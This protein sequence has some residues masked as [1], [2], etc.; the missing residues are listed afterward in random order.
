MSN[1]S[2]GQNITEGPISITSVPGKS[3]TTVRTW[4]GDETSIRAQA[5]LMFADGWTT[6]MEGGPNW[7]LTATFAGETDGQEPI[8]QWE[9]VDVP[10][11]RSILEC[12]DRKFIGILTTTT[13]ELIDY[14][15]KNPLT[16]VG[17]TEDGAEVD[18][19][20]FNAAW[21]VYNYMR[22]GVVARQEFAKQVSR[23]ITVSN[24]FAA[25]F[26]PSPN[27]PRIFSKSSLVS[28]FGVPTWVQEDLPDSSPGIE[29]I[30][31]SI[32]PIYVYYGYLEQGT[33]RR[34]VSNN[35]VQ[36]SQSWLFN[37]WVA[38]PDGLYD[39]V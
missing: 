13:K 6:Q 39:T 1:I 22:I 20:Q 32:S 36:I 24:G 11:E 14:A 4:R 23:T 5:N 27:V 7:T 8:P 31:T 28:E 30:G 26:G 19:A 33:T 9:I 17:L 3:M 12:G 38:G 35:K 2:I 37:R 10:Y 16:H 34:Q 29:N 15:V 18:P 21:Q 25:G